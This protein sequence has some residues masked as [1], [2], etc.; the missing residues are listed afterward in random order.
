VGPLRFA[1]SFTQASNSLQQMAIETWD[2]ELV[3]A[4]QNKFT[5][6]RTL[7]ADDRVVALR[8]LADLTTQKTVVCD[9]D[10]KVLGEFQGQAVANQ[11]PCIL[12]RNKG[13][14]IRLEH[15][16]VR[17]WDGVTM[18][19]AR[20]AT[21]FIER[22]DGGVVPGAVTAGPD[23]RS[24]IVAGQ[25]VPLDQVL[26]FDAGPLDEKAMA[27]KPVPLA[28]MQIPVRKG[29]DE[30]TSVRYSDGT[31]LSGHLSKV[32]DGA[33][34]L[35]HELLP[36]PVMA[37]IEGMERLSIQQVKASN[38]PPE[39][40]MATLDTMH[41]GSAT[42][43]GQLEGTGDAQMRWRLPGA[44]NPVPLMKRPDLEIRRPAREDLQAAPALFFLRDGNVLG[45]ALE[46]VTAKEIKLK[47]GVAEMGVLPAGQLHAIHFN[48]RQKVAQGF[49]DPGWQIV[50]GT[51]AEVER[52]GDNAIIIKGNGAM[53]HGSIMFGDEVQ[54]TM[55]APSFW[56]AL[57]VSLFCGDLETRAKAA[58]LHLI[59]S[60][61]DFWAV[62]ETGENNSRSSEQLRNLTSK[63]I[64]VKLSFTEDA[65]QVFA[66]G[67]PL[68]NAQLDSALRKGAGLIFSPSA[69][70]G[71]P[72]RDVEVS[73]FRIQAR[74]DFVQTPA[75]G[76]EAKKMALT[77]PR[78][79]RDAPPTHVLLAPNGDILRGRI[80][81][82]TAKSVQF[83]SGSEM[84]EV[85]AERLAAAV[86]LDQPKKA[87]KEEAAPVKEPSRD[88]EFAKAIATHWLVLQDGSRLGVKVDKFMPDRIIA[89]SPSLGTVDVPNDRLAMVK[90]AA[91]SPT[92]A[93]LAY[94]GWQPEFAPEPVLP[95]TGGQS[96]PM[97]NKPAPDFALPL[98]GGGQFQL[99]A[100]KGK[101]IVLDFWATW[102]GPCV[103]SMP[104]QLKAMAGFD[105]A[106]VKFIAVNQGEPEPVVQKFLQ[107][108]GW[109]MT[110]ALDS[111]QAIGT[112][113]GV[114]GIPHCVVIDGEGKVVWT[115]TGFV[116]GESEKMAAMI[117]KLLAAPQ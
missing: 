2:D 80:E 41:T 64:Q 111:Q 30:L 3:I 108:R 47:S 48:S 78:F 75:V 27:A 81:S 68:M 52:K 9:W 66:N 36:Q 12:L 102:C 112:K 104:E 65:V 22:V 87:G 58:Q 21:S 77:I 24:F 117:R 4:Q 55:S 101:I 23:G 90:L 93:M 69:M 88:E 31:S 67:I 38:A 39:P 19:G 70:W 50:K 18:P 82:A 103:S 92:S 85:P 99:S 116:P 25:T 71:N 11:K 51:E 20:V 109:Q 8:I 89:W 26:T 63:S 110:V 16:M 45:A 56:G 73:D 43:H 74:P 94:Q 62:L 42:L 5:P 46:S 49:A 13:A 6:L 91:P 37:R 100:E 106:K 15:L 105:P 96:S 98:L 114:E 1:L 32:A 57:E 35:K 60:G 44:L 28:Q 86:W 17:V 10:G 115:N 40:A 14:Q 79:R 72:S 54:F 97:L 84:I 107:A 113:Y 34:S 33:V 53:G 59:F 95:E 7:A 29:A 83:A 76:E 61:T